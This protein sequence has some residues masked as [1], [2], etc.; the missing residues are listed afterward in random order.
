MTKAGPALCDSAARRCAK[1]VSSIFPVAIAAI[2]LAL[3]ASPTLT[4]ALD[5]IEKLEGCRA[6]QDS[7]AR[8]RCFE[9]ATSNLSGSRPSG[10][11]GS[12]EGWRLVRTPNPTGGKDA[13][14]VM[15]TADPLRS[16]Q[17]LA[18]LIIRCGGAGN[19]VLIALIS[20]FPPRARPHVVLGIS[21][22][23]VEAN[24]IPPGAAIL[25]PGEA[26][27]LASGPWQS[28]DEL[29]VQ[30]TEDGTAIR[31]VIPLKGLPAALQALR[32]NCPMN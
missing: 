22:L 20:P 8:L 19:E 31:G 9:N 17:D 28:L 23:R 3:S 16:D 4:E 10:T 5:A 12:M 27:A 13:V 1:M 24:V 11:S 7:A 15:H 32:A 26:S 21:P 18:G 25:L 29:P 6:I 30:I 14:S 2:L